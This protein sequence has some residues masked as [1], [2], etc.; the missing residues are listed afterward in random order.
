MQAG[1]LKHGHRFRDLRMVIG[2]Q[3][4]QSLVQLAQN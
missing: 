2:N 1:S 4:L 3:S